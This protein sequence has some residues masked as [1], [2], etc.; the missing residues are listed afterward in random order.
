MEE[1]SAKQY[2]VLKWASLFLKEHNREEAV[3]PLLLQ[4]YLGISR[5]AFYMRMREDV[6]ADVAHDFRE[7][8]EYHAKTGIPVEHLTG[9]ASF[10]GRAFSV[11]QD[12]LIPRPE[13][14]E[15]VEGV[16][17]YVCR[18]E[19]EASPVIVDIG[20]G[21]G[22]IAITLALE[23]EQACVYAT[24]IS[25][26]ALAVAKRNASSLGADIHVLE[27]D[28]LSPIVENGI[29]PDI[30]VSNPPYIAEKERPELAD[31]VREFDPERALFADENGLDIYKRLFRQLEHAHAHPNLIAV[32]IGHTQ[33]ESV[34]HIVKKTY[35]E[36]RVH[37]RQDINEKDRMVFVEKVD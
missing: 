19:W 14:E 11:N 17:D 21:S 15:L 32:E 3:A 27:G 1:K 8:I 23:L 31:T 7:A 22:T 2:E 25:K 5:S 33:G 16:L 18:C 20:T 26:A 30:I 12:V 24:D 4:Y 36:S 29:R 10:Y 35:P 37:I 6:P 9:M 13:T 28:L 34:K